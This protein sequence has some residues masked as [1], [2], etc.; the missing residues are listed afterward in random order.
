MTMVTRL[1][2]RRANGW[3]GKQNGLMQDETIE[4]SFIPA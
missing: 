1:R 3:A 4:S 2:R